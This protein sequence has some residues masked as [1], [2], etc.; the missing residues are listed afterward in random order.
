MKKLDD[1][2]YIFQKNKLQGDMGENV[3]PPDQSSSHLEPREKL[4]YN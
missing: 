2:F 3:S 1:L 4:Q